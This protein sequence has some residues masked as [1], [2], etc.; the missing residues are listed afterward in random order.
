MENNASANKPR[1]EL[2]RSRTVPFLDAET[3]AFRTARE[4]LFRTDGVF[5][6]YLSDGRSA[7][8]AEE[9]VIKLSARE[10]LIWLNEGVE[11][12]GSFWN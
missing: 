6:L 7:P 4:A 5:I 10:A 2:V 1:M 3:L 12:A 9:R 11:E 8:A